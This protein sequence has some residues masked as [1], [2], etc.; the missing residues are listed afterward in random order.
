MYIKEFVKFE[1]DDNS[2]YHVLYPGNMENIDFV[3]IFFD[4]GF[5]YIYRDGASTFIEKL[6][7]IY[8]D[9]MNFETIELSLDNENNLAYVSEPFDW[10]QKEI[11]PEIDALIETQSTIELCHRN[12]IGYAVM[13]KE[14]LF[15]IL[16]K[17]EELCNKKDL[18]IL[19]YKDDKDWYDSTSF[20]SKES[21]NMFLAEHG[22][23][24]ENER[25][26][27]TESRQNQDRIK[28]HF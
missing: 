11:T 20:D 12:F 9:G 5:S 10:S 7:T 26:I 14:N 6:K 1:L 3:A 8:K 4:D 23:Q 24:E 28:V 21:M 16:L 13:T 27:K 19:I 18:Y 22:Q 17:W 15:H 2:Y 25:R